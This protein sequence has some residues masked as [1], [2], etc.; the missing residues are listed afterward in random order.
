MSNI[1]SV[2]KPP[3]EINSEFGLILNCAVRYAL[4]RMTYMPSS[5]IRYITPLLPYIDDKTLDC[6][7]QDITRYGIDVDKGIG[8][9]GM[10]IDKEDWLSFLEL[11]NKE[12]RKRNEN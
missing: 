9:W 6:F 4:G 8:S 3:V 10:D 7:I 5:V 2:N 1:E 12:M 11:C